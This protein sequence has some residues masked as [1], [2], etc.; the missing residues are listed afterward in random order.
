[1]MRS[2]QDVV[3]NPKPAADA[4]AALGRT[5]PSWSLTRATQI[6][7]EELEGLAERD[8]ELFTVRLARWPAGDLTATFNFSE[9]R[10]TVDTVLA[11]VSASA[12]LLDLL[13][14]SRLPSGDPIEV[15]R[16]GVRWLVRFEPQP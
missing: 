14:G 15:P 12:T 9:V 5:V 11:P 10:R 13:D 6:V 16:L 1:M 8:I 2:G 7:V 4:T 3:G